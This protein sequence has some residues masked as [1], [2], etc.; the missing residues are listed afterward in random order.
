[1]LG[2]A[3][4]LAALGIALLAG[5]QGL[6]WLLAGRMVQGSAQAMAIGNATAAMVEFAPLAARR[7]A[8]LLTAIAAQ[9]GASLGPLIGG[10][11]AEYLAW[12]LRLVYL[13]ELG[14]LLIVLAATRTMPGAGTAERPRV[15]LHRPQVSRSIAAPFAAAPFAA[16]ASAAGLAWAMGGLFL[17]LVP[18]YTTSLL[19]SHNLVIGALVVVVMVL[20][21]GAAEVTLQNLDPRGQQIGGLLVLVVGL[22]LVVLAHPLSSPVLVFCGALACGAGLGMAFLGGISTVNEIALPEQRGNISSL[23]FAITYL[24]Q[25]IPSLGVGALATRIGLYPAVRDFAIVIGVIA[26]ANVAWS[27]RARAPAAKPAG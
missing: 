11:F 1:V 24:C 22:A 3:V 12:P 13:V 14:L 27:L 7:R 19:G 5:A 17:R 15:R 2:I 21:S 4:A 16:A 8:A 26:L 23:F 10:L 25:G 6:G 9:G 20:S 18:S